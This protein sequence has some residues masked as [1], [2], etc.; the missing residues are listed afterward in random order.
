[1]AAAIENRAHSQSSLNRNGGLVPDRGRGSP[2]SWSS[3]SRPVRN[4]IEAAEAVG[5]PR[6]ALA[7]RHIARPVS[8]ERATSGLSLTCPFWCA[9]AT[10]T[11]CTPTVR[12]TAGRLLLSRSAGG[13]RRPFRVQR[14]L[15]AP[16]C[17]RR[18]PGQRLLPDRFGTRLAMPALRVS[19]RRRR[20]IPY[21][22][23]A[24]RSPAARRTQGRRLRLWRG[25]GRS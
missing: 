16:P 2:S 8:R 12:S 22:R 5:P 9:P 7:V 21:A 4:W 20:R 17:S 3:T 14:A 15:A 18:R 25:A 6:L 19:R 1:M 11:A 23:R 10:P 24:R 13:K